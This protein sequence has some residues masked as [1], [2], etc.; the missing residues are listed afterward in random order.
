M[1]A[2]EIRDDGLLFIDFKNASKDS[3]IVLFTILTA[4]SILLLL[5]ITKQVYRKEILCVRT[6]I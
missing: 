3:K 4:I 6:N 1:K 5:I 2:K